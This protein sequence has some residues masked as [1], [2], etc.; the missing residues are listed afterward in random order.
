M[1][2]EIMHVVKHVVLDLGPS[3][4]ILVLSWSYLDLDQVCLGLILILIKY[5]QKHI[6]FGWIQHFWDSLFTVNF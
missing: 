1:H 4:Y 6:V 2:L 3:K 5:V